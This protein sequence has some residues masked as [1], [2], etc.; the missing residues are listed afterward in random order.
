MPNS[1]KIS[2]ATASE[3][4]MLRWLAKEPGFRFWHQAGEWHATRHPHYAAAATPVAALRKL[5]RAVKKGT[6]NA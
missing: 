5:C 1:K 6:P 4:T 3:G 2:F